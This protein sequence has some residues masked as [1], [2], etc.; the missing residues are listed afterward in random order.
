MIL[1]LLGHLSYTDANKLYFMFI[2]EDTKTKL[3]KCARKELENTQYFVVEM[4]S[5]FK[6]V[7][8]DIR[9]KIGLS[10]I[11]H[12]TTRFYSFK[13]TRRNTG[14]NVSGYRLILDDIKLYSAI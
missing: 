5:L 7:P 6:T 13:S 10:C 12:V 14:E 9:S 1:R 3:I 8:E 11:I 4:P 2:D